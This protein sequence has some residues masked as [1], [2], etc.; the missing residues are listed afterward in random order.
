MP[1]TF[2]GR[3]PS[4]FL[5]RFLCK[6]GTGSGFA[7]IFLTANTLCSPVRQENPASRACG[8]NM[9]I[10][11]FPWFLHDCL[12]K[13]S[14]NYYFELTDSFPPGRELIILFPT[15]FV[16]KGNT[17]AFQTASTARDTRINPN[18]PR[19]IPDGARHDPRQVRRMLDKVKII[20]K[21][22]FGK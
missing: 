4:R 18:S 19:N 11:D 6:I 12:A 21:N 9:Q 14:R 3:F 16:M 15:L 8:K 20:H 5:G 13:P 17:C 10:L 2:P 7:A 22:K 1:S